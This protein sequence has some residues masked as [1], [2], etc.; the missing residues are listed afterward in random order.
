MA[1]KDYY[2]ILGL[3][4]SA[5]ASDIK[6]AYRKLAMKYHPDHAKDDKAAEDK[7]KQISEAYA[8]LSDPGKRKEYDTYGAAGFQQR[9]SQEDIFRNFDFGDIFREFG[10]SAGG[11]STGDGGTRFS[12]GGGPFGGSTFGGRRQQAA[13]KGSDLM[14]E[15][16]LTLYEVANGATKSI[17]LQHQGRAD[18]ITVKIPKGMISG[19]K[20]RLA[21]KGEPSPYGGPTGDLFIFSKVVA[22][23][24]FS[25]ENYD[26]F[27]NREI[28]LTDALLGTQIFVPTLEG[29]EMA[30]KI[31]PGTRHKTKMRLA[32]QGLPKMKSSERGDLYVVILVDMPRQLTAEQMTLARKLADTGL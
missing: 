22:D 14:Y 23:P 16:P 27:V 29:K 30:L 7:F 11:T 20:L 1:E 18:T 32:G 28:K 6:K 24:V 12:F 17:S 10:F 8:V 15:M 5:S 21:G 4:K 26:L 25:V 31:P 9:F 2:K 19:R 13:V 3:E